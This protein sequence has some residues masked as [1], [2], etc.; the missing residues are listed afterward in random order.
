[1]VLFTTRHPRRRR[2]PAAH[3]AR[4]VQFREAGRTVAPRSPLDRRSRG[5]VLFFVH[6]L[7]VRHFRGTERLSWRNGR[8]V[9][10]AGWAARG[11]PVAVALSVAPIRLSLRRDS[12]HLAAD[13]HHPQDARAPLVGCESRR[14]VAANRGPEPC[15]VRERRRH[16]WC[17]APVAVLVS[18]V[19]PAP[20]PRSSRVE[21]AKVGG[22]AEVEEF[23]DRFGWR[24]R[25]GQTGDA[26]LLLALR[27]GADSR[28]HGAAPTGAE[29]GPR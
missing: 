6:V 11:G 4:G 17:I 28:R 3:D 18:S 13:A 12:K 23:Y 21:N 5:H 8:R 19:D 1:M 15:G 22:N 27:C 25:T 2:Q 29:H 14:T 26:Q 10:W 16:A 9:A 24:V 20:S 7:A